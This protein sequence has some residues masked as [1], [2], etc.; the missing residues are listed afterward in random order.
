MNTP[1]VQEGVAG[2]KKS[3]GSI[4]FKFREGHINLMAGNPWRASNLHLQ[5]QDAW[6]AGSIS[7]NIDPVFMALTGL[8]GT[9]TCVAAGTNSRK[10]FQPLRLRTP[11]LRN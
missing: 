7:H 10:K 6:A 3:V 9:A 1:S 2:D 5:S 11:D 8:T 4:A